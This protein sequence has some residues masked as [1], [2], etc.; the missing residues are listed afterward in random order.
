MLFANLRTIKSKI[1]LGFSILTLMLIVV[2]SIGL[3]GIQRLSD[4]LAFITGPAWDTADGAME[5]SIGIGAQMLAV[6][7]IVSGKDYEQNLIAFN[8]AV[9]VANEAISQ[10][11]EAGL[12]ARDQVETVTDAIDIHHTHTQALFS[13]YQDFDT[14]RTAFKR[15]VAEFVQLGEEM[16]EIGDGAVE[17]IE[18]NPAA[19]YRWQGDLDQ[20][21]AAAD[22]GMESNI[23]LLW[24][25]YHVGRFLAQ[26]GD[27]AE[28][29]EEILGAIE[30]QKEASNEMLSTGRFDIAAGGTWGD[31]TFNS[32][33]KEYFQSYEASLLALIMA[34][35]TYQA[36]Y[37]EY[38]QSA[39][40]LL[41]ILEKFEESGDAAIEGQIT[42]IEKVK[43]NTQTLM[44]AATI[45]G[46]VMAIIFTFV[47]VRLVINPIKEVVNRIKNIAQGDGDLTQRIDIR[48]Q[49][50]MGELAMEF[51]VFID[52]VHVIVKQVSSNCADM[53]T[54]MQ[55]MLVITQAASEKVDEQR[56]QTDQI[57]TAFNE[58]S[59]TSREISNN[60]NNASDVANSANSVSND[61]KKV[62]GGAIQTIN[63][64]ASEIEEAS[65]VISSLEEN[66]TK[67]VS[68][69]T[70]IQ[71]IAEQTNLL[72]LNAAIEAARAGEQ[73]RGFAVVAD[74]VRS[75]ASKTQDSTEEIRVMI[76][77][78]QSGSTQ[79][80]QVMA[81]SKI[82]GQETVSQSENVSESLGNMSTLITQINDL[83]TQV[84][85]ASEEQT[86][87]SEEMN[88][89]VQSIVGLSD[90]VNGRITD[91]ALMCE[92][93]ASKTRQLSEL[94]N[95]F[96]V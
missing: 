25:L 2:G 93:L 88:H 30:F 68:V 12:M 15:L 82:R 45:I 28:T 5:G 47:L 89:S 6:S 67:I 64:L 18:A 91:S 48:S 40:N 23:G 44:I 79:A 63:K 7:A 17:E 41:G 33:Y 13:T 52:N 69:L 38:Q 21:W 35:E 26:E 10:L 92:G 62:V 74:E 65:E 53:A 76:E 56:E 77:R 70:V 55:E 14:K 27:A 3:Y 96:K 61:A 66:V 84:A 90:E 20:R 37:D 29:K 22:G 80:V 8:E 94:V 59:S 49:D 4:N 78:L 43:S 31:R 95:K 54:S 46:A 73:G 39:Q 16:E 60:T 58:L 42:P 75:L 81:Q 19:F 34:T 32:L 51:N 85:S 1:I 87:V 72:A 71:G 50:E 86:A 83:N 57:A 24:G 9:D 11:I 36:S